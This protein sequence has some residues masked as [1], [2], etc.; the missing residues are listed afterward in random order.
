LLAV[1]EKILEKAFLHMDTIQ[2]PADGVMVNL[3]YHH[4]SFPETD[5]LTD[6]V[7]EPGPIEE[8]KFYFSG[9][10]LRAFMKKELSSRDLLSRTQVF[11]DDKPVVFTLPHGTQKAETLLLSPEGNSS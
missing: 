6:H 5:D 1:W 4:K 9:D 8:A 7:D 11:V 10:R 3:V 2:V